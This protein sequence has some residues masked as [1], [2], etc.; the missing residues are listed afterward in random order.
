[1]DAQSV[2]NQSSCYD[3][4]ESDLAAAMLLYVF[5]QTAN[6]QPV[7]TDPQT[8][9]GA[10]KC[11]QCIISQGMFFPTL[12]YVISQTADSQP[13][14]DDP[15]Q[16]ANDARCFSCLIP[17]GLLPAAL[18]EEAVRLNQAITQ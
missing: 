4:V 9:A 10:A 14:S 15:S 8:I 18:V 13:V 6:G 12:L 5:V 16:L 2:I 1:M 11:Y 3:C 17:T 7:A